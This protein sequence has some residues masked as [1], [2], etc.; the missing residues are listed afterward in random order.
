MLIGYL[1]NR[2][3]SEDALVVR[4]QALN[5]AGCERVIEDLIFGRRWE[6][7]ELRRMLE[8]LHPDDMIIV[9]RLGDLGR[10]LPEVVRC[11]GRI[12]TVGAGLRSL[13]EGID[14]A[15]EAGQ[16]AVRTIGNLAALDRS[17]AREGITAG[18][19]AAAAEGRRSG[20]RPKLT[21]QQRL[22]IADDVLGGR[23][24]AARAARRYKVS[25]PTIS[26]IITAH[27]V[28]AEAPAAGRTT[29][30]SN[31]IAGVLPLAALND[32][33]AI[34]GTSGSGKT[35]AAKGLAEHLM[36]GGGRLC[37]VDPLG[38][39]WG[40]RA[41]PD[42]ALPP[43]FSVTVFGGRH[44]DFPLTPRMGAAL[45]RLVGTHAGACVVDVSDLGSAAAQRAFM[46]A[47]TETLF[48]ANDEPLHLVLDE[49]D[50]WAPQ[51][52]HQDGY[53]L[54]N[55]VDEI[56]RRGH[57]RGFVPWLI[58]QRPAVLHKD[59]LSQADILVSMKLT[60]SQDREAIGR[61]ILGQADRAVGQRILAE[62][63]QLGRGEGY[64]WAPSDS[65]LARVAFPRIRTFDSS[66]APRREA[67][68]SAPSQLAPLDLSAIRAALAGMVSDVPER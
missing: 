39:W 47:F 11:V 6:Q 1:R 24:T 5:D 8:A 52:V 17:A 58:T 42:G 14:T 67:L 9:A 55:R 13:E 12:T 62:L 33:L 54:L 56:V 28:R 22:E 25:K 10:S 57:V 46:T 15:T 4:R 68:G 18:L 53:D 36:D 43:P 20:R 49:A 61:W 26:R 60:S 63:P 16:A 35:Y 23:S 31:K 32:R 37:V 45:G 27:R 50:L 48:A 19:A 44:A 65:V 40:L 59:V 7:P 38:V 2:T 3:D 66:Q 30:D 34:V 21:E 51:R 29:L 41:A 64:L